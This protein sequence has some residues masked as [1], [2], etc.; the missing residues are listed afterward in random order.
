MPDPNAGSE[1]PS[2]KQH[3][4][5]PRLGVKAFQRDWDYIRRLFVTLAVLG[6]AYFLW[7][8]SGVLLLV[9]AAVLLA[10]L[11]RS[12]ANTVA[13]Y[14]PVP[15]GWALAVAIIT[16]AGVLIGAI[17]LFG[18]QIAGQITFIVERLPAALDATGDQLGISNASAQLEK[19]ISESSGGGVLSRAA[20]LGYTVLGVLADLVLVVVASIY[21]AA[22]PKLYRRGTA[23]LLPPSQHQRIFD[24]MD[25]TGNALR[26]WFLGQLA[27]MAIVWVASGLAYW[28][29]GLPSPLA[30]ATIAALTNFVPYLGA[31]VGA[32][33]AL[34]FAFSMNMETVFWTAGAVLVIQQFEGNVVTP[35]VQSRAV[36]MPPVVVLF[37]I[38]VFGLVFGVLGILL[39]VP[40]AVAVTVLVKKLWIRQ[41]LGEETIVPGEE[42]AKADSS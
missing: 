3:A 15:E 14:T 13:R 28:W 6:L 31:I 34:V 18:S 8:I 24:A 32:I 25:T 9:F 30:L 1:V 40:L 26:L 7:R 22:D 20:G 17:I 23:K 27:T 29:I 4:G 11:L 21:L 16:A 10:V 36:S 41:T 39:A 35:F 2:A 5:R 42:G 12:F 38:L 19:T 33:P 37:A